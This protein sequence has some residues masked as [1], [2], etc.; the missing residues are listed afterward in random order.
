[1][2][3]AD[4]CREIVDYLRPRD[5]GHQTRCLPRWCVMVR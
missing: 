2:M 3:T 1:M 4:V 5:R